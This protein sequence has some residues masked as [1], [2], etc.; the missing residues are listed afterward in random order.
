[1][2]AEKEVK[3][4]NQIIAIVESEKTACIMS[5]IFDKYTWLA[6][7]SLSGLSEAKLRVIKQHKIILYPDLGLDKKNV[8]PFIKWSLQKDRLNKLGYQ[9]SISDLLERKGTDNQKTNGFDIA[10]YFVNQFKQ[11]KIIIETSEE[12]VYKKI[13]K[14]CPDIECLRSVFDIDK[15]DIIINACE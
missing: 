12:L 5:Q 15:K 1:M 10:D 7:G 4:K 6:C 8:S 9:I 11:E 14:K 2:L 13:R 3:N